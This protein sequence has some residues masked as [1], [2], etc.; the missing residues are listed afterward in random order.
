MIDNKLTCLF[1]FWFTGG[2]SINL[3]VVASKLKN[4][5]TVRFKNKNWATV[6][7]SF[8]WLIKSTVTQYLQYY[9]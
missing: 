2:N 6:E 1:L 9:K 5:M 7:F 3:D 8:R 4:G